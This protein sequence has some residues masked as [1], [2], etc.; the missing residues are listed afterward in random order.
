MIKTNLVAFVV[1]ALVLANSPQSAHA[2]PTPIPLIYCTRMPMHLIIFKFIGDPWPPQHSL[3]PLTGTATLEGSK[4]TS[5]R[6]DLW[7][8]EDWIL[9]STGELGSVSRPGFVT[10]PPSFSMDVTAPPVGVHSGTKSFGEPP[11]DIVVGDTELEKSASSSTAVVTL[12]FNGESGFVTEPVPGDF[13]FHVE[14]KDAD[15]EWVTC[16]ELPIHAQDASFA[17]HQVASA[18][19]LSMSGLILGVLLLAGTGLVGLARRGLG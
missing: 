3:A 16:L 4:L 18:P 13:Y 15:G 14:I 7:L 11:S 19:A 8:G 17:V 10:L 5:L 6:L 12:R 2:A 1:T 9:H